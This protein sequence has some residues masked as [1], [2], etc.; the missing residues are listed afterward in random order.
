MLAGGFIAQNTTWRWT[1]WSV[2]CLCVAIQLVAIFFLRET[3]APRLLA[4]KAK[5]LR[6]KYK[7]PNLGTEWD[8]KTLQQLLRVSLTRPWLFLATQP[9]VQIMALY[10]AFNWGMLYLIISSLPTLWEE[11]YGMSKAISSLHYLSLLGSLI[12]SQLFG[13]INDNIHRRLKAKYNPADGE[14]VP[15]FRIPLMIPASIITAAGIFL[16]GWSAEAKL[17]WILPDVS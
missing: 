11:R 5:S 9:I 10:Q 2:S 3:Y 13:P 6:R 7:N 12:A 16:F 4:I 14:V 1:F 17:H 8:D 15:E